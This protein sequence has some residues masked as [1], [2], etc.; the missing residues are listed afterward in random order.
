NVYDIFEEAVRQLGLLD[1]ENNE[2]DKYLD[3]AAIYQM[4]SKL[5]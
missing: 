2:F 1:K 5:K 3:K 4:P